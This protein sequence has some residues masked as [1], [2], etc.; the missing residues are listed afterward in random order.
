MH[1][2]TTRHAVELTAGTGD[3]VLDPFCG[4]GTT[5][6]EARRVGAKAIGVDANPLAVLIARAKTWTAP[7]AQRVLMGKIGHD[8]A[9]DA[10]AAGKAARRANNREKPMR[11]PAGVDPVVRNRRLQGWFPPHVRRELEQLAGGV[12]EVVKRDREIADML[13]VVLS[14]ILY[15][16]SL[17]ASDT[18]PSKVDRKIGRGAAA[19]L[20]AQRV[21]ALCTGLD[22][23]SAGD[24]VPRPEVHLGDA[25]ELAKAGIGDGT[26][27]AVV[28]SPPYAGTYDYSEQHRLRL[29]FLGLSVDEFDKAEIGSR[30][31]F[32][33]DSTSRRL[34]RRAWQRSLTACLGEIA[35]VLQP[36]GRA[37]VVMGDSVAGGRAMSA[38]EAIKKAAED[39]LTLTA[40]ASQ[41]RPLLGAMERTAF[42]DTPKREYV[43]LL[44]P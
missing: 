38:E 10:L 14:S 2:A 24:D 12:D 25:R 37:I 7:K 4:S 9:E 18:D 29:D 21:D 23:L 44:R 40:W 32:R 17:R 41:R 22:E 1:P 3:V 28:T 42:G 43:F 35:R 26:I 34:A 30:R 36:R 11:A 16:V 19:R 15:K 13:L 39:R 33:G 27:D 8:I 31:K 6:V 20:F 5:L